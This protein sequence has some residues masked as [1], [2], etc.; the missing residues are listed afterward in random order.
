MS[1]QGHRLRDPAVP[2]FRSAGSSSSDPAGTLRLRREA[3]PLG[4]CR[5][6]ALRAPPHAL[7]KDRLGHLPLLRLPRPPQPL[8]RRGHGF[9]KA[10]SGK[11]LG[12]DPRDDV[13]PSILIVGSKR[14]N[15]SITEGLVPN[16][17]FLARNSV[18]LALIITEMF[19]MEYS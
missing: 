2:S 14:N 19:P 3:I 9:A 11:A 8:R 6:T 12:S 4:P 5:L 16:S 1:P 10:R 17:H 15:G 7:I 13:F 18:G